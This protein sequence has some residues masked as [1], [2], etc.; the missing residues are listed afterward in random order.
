MR[1][2]CT[3]KLYHAEQ[4]KTRASFGIKR[5][6]ETAAGNPAAVK[7]YNSLV[8]DLSVVMLVEKGADDIIDQ[9][10]FAV[11]DVEGEGRGKEDEHDERK[12]AERFQQERKCLFHFCVLL[13]LISSRVVEFDDRWVEGL[14]VEHDGH[15]VVYAVAHVLTGDR[16]AVLQVMLN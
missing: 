5:Q 6:I 3:K 11:G 12:L 15:V 16:A 10:V 7:L 14:L 8:S 4:R 2:L 9:L 1:R 13:S